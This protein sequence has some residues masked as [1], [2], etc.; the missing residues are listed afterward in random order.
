MSRQ[1]VSN[2]IE[3]ITVE[4]LHFLKELLILLD[5]LPSPYAL[6]LKQRLILFSILFHIQL[7]T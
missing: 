6:I 5:S 3:L 4:P 1:N 2:L 7:I